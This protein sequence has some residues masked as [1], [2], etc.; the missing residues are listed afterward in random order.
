MLHT[1]YLSNFFP[2][3]LWTMFRATE[4]CNVDRWITRVISTSTGKI[5]PL[6][7]LNENGDLSFL[8]YFSKQCLEEDIQGKFQKNSSV[9]FILKNN[10]KCYHVNIVVHLLTFK[11]KIKVS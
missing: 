9:T 4:N 7:L 5:G 1:F 2:S 3:I 8:L 11:G 6:H 10:L